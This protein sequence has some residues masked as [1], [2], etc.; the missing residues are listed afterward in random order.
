LS[1]DDSL[2]GYFVRQSTLDDEQPLP[3]LLLW[4]SALLPWWSAE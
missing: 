3:A 2:Q 4:W 1:H